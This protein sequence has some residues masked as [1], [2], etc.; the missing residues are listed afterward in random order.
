MVV[1]H[2]WDKDCREACLSGINCCLAARASLPQQVVTELVFCQSFMQDLS[3]ATTDE[4]KT[5][6]ENMLASTWLCRELANM[7]L[8][9]ARLHAIDVQI[10]ESKANLQHEANLEAAL[11]EHA[12]LKWETFGTISAIVHKLTSLRKH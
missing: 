3:G 10:A 4:L 2:A 9:A 7:P 8:G 12:P 11:I 6:K 1:Q 5:I